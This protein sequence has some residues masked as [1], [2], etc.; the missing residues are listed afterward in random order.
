MA[1]YIDKLASKETSDIELRNDLKWSNAFM[2]EKITKAVALGRDYAQNDGSNHKQ[3][4]IDQMLRTLL[5]ELGFD[6]FVDMY[7]KD[8][9]REWEKGKAPSLVRV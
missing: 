2:Q 6:N 1:K 7:E 8:S 4:I 3:W 5:G 9:G